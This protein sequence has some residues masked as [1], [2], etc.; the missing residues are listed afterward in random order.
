MSRNT[1]LPKS[2]KTPTADAMTDVRGKNVSG[3]K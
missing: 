2:R 3:E 1:V